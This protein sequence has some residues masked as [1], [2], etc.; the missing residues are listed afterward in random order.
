MQAW[1]SLQRR[2]AD[3]L[4]AWRPQG[5]VRGQGSLKSLQNGSLFLARCQPGGAAADA[6]APTEPALPVPSS[7]QSAPG[8]GREVESTSVLEPVHDIDIRPREAADT[9]RAFSDYATDGGTVPHSDVEPT[10]D[11]LSGLSQ[12]LRSGD[13]SGPGHRRVYRAIAGSIGADAV[14]RVGPVGSQVANGT[15]QTYGGARP[16]PANPHKCGRGLNAGKQRAY[17]SFSA[18]GYKL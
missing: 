1:S 7:A 4:R 10:E 11:Q 8:T 6:A 9:E 2:R 5:A 12:L 3:G 13:P 18:P 15:H 14:K 17:H 16:G